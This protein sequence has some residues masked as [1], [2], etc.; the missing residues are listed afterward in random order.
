MEIANP[1]Y[2]VVFKYLMQDSRVSKLL[3]SKIIEEEIL[4]IDCLPHDYPV[5]I[6]TEAKSLTVLRL[7]FSA[8]IKTP[9]GTK[10]VLIEIQKGKFA[11]DLMRFRRYL[12]QQ[13]QNRENVEDVVVKGRMIKQPIPIITIYFL[14]HELDHHKDIP[15]IKVK[16]HYY[17]A[18][19]GQKITERETFIESLTHDSFVIQIPSLK[20]K[21]RNDLEQFLGIFDQS[22][23]GS[24]DHLLNINEEDYPEECRPLIRRLLQAYSEPE[25]RN[26]MDVE[27]E[28]LEELQDLERLIEQ[29]DK[30]LVDNAKV[31]SQNAKVLV[32]KDKA[33]DEKDKALDEK[34]RI[35]QT[36]QRKLEGKG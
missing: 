15:V 7:D 4:S 28:I 12:G 25:V 27:D 23:I 5:H 22:N 18:A 11:S 35:I 21:R 13:Y 34:D 33:L 10:Q 16:R 9:K 36:L 30:V 20:E 6:Q 24:N 14:G 26:A 32:E 31:L 2:D 19:T 1:I 29:K 17:D 8:K 3:I